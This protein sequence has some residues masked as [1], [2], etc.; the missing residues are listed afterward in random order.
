LVVSAR[1]DFLIHFADADVRTGV[2]Y[3]HLRNH[4]VAP[5]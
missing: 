2:I 1:E 3:E 5:G 4:A